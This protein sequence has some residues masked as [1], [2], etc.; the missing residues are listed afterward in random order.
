MRHEYRPIYHHLLTHKIGLDKYTVS[1]RQEIMSE[2]EKKGMGYV[3][4][5]EQEIKN[6]PT[7]DEFLKRREVIEEGK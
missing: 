7:L 3:V 6:S 5:R 4:E 2:L 1:F